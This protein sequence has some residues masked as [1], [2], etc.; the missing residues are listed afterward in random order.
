MNCLKQI[1]AQGVGS[2]CI[3][4]N[5]YQSISDVFKMNNLVSDICKI[6]SGKRTFVGKLRNDDSKS[7]AVKFCETEGCIIGTASCCG[8]KAYL[9]L[10]NKDLLTKDFAWNYIDLLSRLAYNIRCKK[11]LS[12][13]KDV[14]CK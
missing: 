7:I 9:M 14:L 10:P 6:L 4:S 5:S 12:T 3:D 8:E 11:A 2:I 1:D 13:A